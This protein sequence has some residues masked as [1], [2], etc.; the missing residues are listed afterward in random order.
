MV[1][2]ANLQLQNFVACRAAEGLEGKWVFALMCERK[3]ISN[4]R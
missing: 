2:H 1:A 4:P 3:K